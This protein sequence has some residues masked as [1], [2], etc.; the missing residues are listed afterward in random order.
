LAKTLGRVLTPNLWKCW[1][2]SCSPIQAEKL[3]KIQYQGYLNNTHL[4]SRHLCVQLRLVLYPKAVN[5][6]LTYISL[7]YFL[8]IPISEHQAFWLIRTHL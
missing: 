4:D 5:A 8:N 1:T 3:D 7:T 6:I 2:L